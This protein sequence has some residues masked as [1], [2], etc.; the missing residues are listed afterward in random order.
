[1]I[2]LK[3][4]GLVLVFSTTKMLVRHKIPEVLKYRKKQKRYIYT[5]LLLHCLA[6]KSH[7]DMNVH[8]WKTTG[9][10]NCMC[11]MKKKQALGLHPY[12]LILEYICILYLCIF[13]I[14]IYLFFI[15]H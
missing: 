15:S 9:C 6:D 4:N 13:L 5:W 3:H 11:Q 1:M 2:L 8:A 7:R 14:I 12:T 10:L